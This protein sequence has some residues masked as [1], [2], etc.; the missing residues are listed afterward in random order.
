MVDQLLGGLFGAK[1]DDDE[2]TRRRRARDY[3]DRYERGAYDQIGDDEVLH[4]YRTATSHL[5][6]DEYHQAAADAVRQMSPEQ[7]RELRRELKRRSR[8]RFD[9]KDDS[10]EEV[11]R[12]MQQA[13]QETRAAADWRG[14]LAWAARMLPLANRRAAVSA[15]C[16][17]TRSPKSRWPVSPRW[18]RKSSRTRTASPE[19]TSFTSPRG[20]RSFTDENGRA[21]ERDRSYLL[22]RGQVLIR[23]MG[24]G[25]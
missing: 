24:A 23:A 16:S 21:P 19:S 7:R 11:A 20:E 3:V 1:D 9:A 12:A 17:T 25:Q 2:P 18:W 5:S 8:D 14:S 13:D 15:G 22:E 6:P 4:N 10:P